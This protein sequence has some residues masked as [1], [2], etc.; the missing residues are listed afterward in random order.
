MGSS[1]ASGREVEQMVS[2]L[3][4]PYPILGLQPAL[5]YPYL[6]PLILLSLYAKLAKG[7]SEEMGVEELTA[8]GALSERLARGSSSIKRG[9]PVPQCWQKSFETSRP[10]IEC[11]SIMNAMIKEAARHR[12]KVQPLPPVGFPCFTNELTYEPLRGHLHKAIAFLLS[13][14]MGG[15]GL[16]LTA[17][18]LLSAAAAAEFNISMM[19][20]AGGSG[21][22]SSNRPVHVD[23]NLPPGAWDELSDLVAELEQVESQVEREI[24]H[25]AE[26]PTEG[27]EARQER[28]QRLKT[29][30]DEIDSRLDQ[31]R[32]I[33]RV[34]SQEQARQQAELNSLMDGWNPFLKRRPGLQL[35]G[36][37]L[38]GL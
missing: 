10:R 30:L 2:E 11:E 4:S 29:V 24:R 19:A 21:D 28:F 14:L 27:K 36:R 15:E 23:L 18:A 1:S 22:G 16:T 5:I 31:A 37:P 35:G 20:P 38:K 33:D 13:R 17:L 9:F 6:L 26:S 25:L 3:S 32:E 7:L 12:S 34:R 8:G